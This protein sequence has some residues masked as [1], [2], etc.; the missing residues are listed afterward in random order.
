M[1]E[2]KKA[3]RIYLSFLTKFPF[4]SRPT[5]SLVFLL[6]LMYLMDIK[7]LATVT[8]SWAFTFLISFLHIWMMSLYSS[9]VTCPCFH[10]LYACFF[11]FEFCQLLLVHPFRFS[12]IFAW[13]PA[14]W[15]EQFL[16]LEQDI[17]DNQAPF[18]DPSLHNHLLQ[19]SSEQIPAQVINFS[20][21]V[22]GHDPAF[23]FFPLLGMLNSTIS[24]S[25]QLRLPPAFTFL[26]S[27]SCL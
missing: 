6:L 23:C 1:S 17:L 24:W 21:E 4:S 10:L 27:S 18:L 7:S 26:I 14:F 9:W 5:H 19:N 8:S 22:C 15:D 11:V 3:L 16:S 20:T 13:F 25:L 2:V 12:A